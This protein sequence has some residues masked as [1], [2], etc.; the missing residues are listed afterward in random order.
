MTPPTQQLCQPQPQGVR[1]PVVRTSLGRPVSFF[2][3]RGV[4]ETGRAPPAA[5]QAARPPGPRD[6]ARPR[7]RA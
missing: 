6:H 2:W 3:R 5:R 1:I 7:E 4:T